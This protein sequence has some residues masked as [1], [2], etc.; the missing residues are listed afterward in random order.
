ME[1]V[2]E[3]S[4]LQMMATL[5][6]LLPMEDKTFLY[7]LLLLCKPDSR[8]CLT[9]IVMIKSVNNDILIIKIHPQIKILCQFEFVLEWV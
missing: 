6:K 5:L 3:G 9:T 4:I 8:L 1:M 2:L 7:I